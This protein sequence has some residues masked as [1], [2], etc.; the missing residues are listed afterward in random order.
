ML[1]RF[2]RLAAHA[3]LAE[4]GY[5]SAESIGAGACGPSLKAEV[6]AFARDSP[7]SAGWILGGGEGSGLGF[8]ACRR[9][10]SDG[11]EFLGVL[12]VG[13]PSPRAGLTPGQR[14]A[15]DDLAALAVA[16]LEQERR[17][18]LLL[19]V[20]GRAA[21]ADRI[22]RE[23]SESV[24]CEEALTRVLSALC[25][26]HGASVGRIWRLSMPD[27][28]MH[29]VSR[30]A[31][32]W[33]DQHPYYL[34]TPKE[35]VRA[36]NSQTAASIVANQPHT[37]IYSEVADP[38]HYA[39]LE[40]A[41]SAGLRSQVSFP[42]WVQEQRFGIA[43]AFMTERHDLQEIV[44][45]IAS[46]SNT[47][48]PAL[49]RKVTEERIRFMAHHDELTQLSNR[50][51][52]NERL[53]EAMQAVTVRD[54][55]ALLY[56][57]LDGF[58][59]VN[60]TRGHEVGDKLL[61]AAAARLR[62]SVPDGDTVAR[63]GGDEFAIIHPAAGQPYSA[64]QLARVLL[65]AFT[66][67]FD[68]D[69]PPLLIGASIG[70]AFHP[71]DGQTPDVLQRSADAALYAA[72]HGGRNTFRL[73][74]RALGEAKQDRLLIERDL[75]DA[76][77]HEEFTLVYQPIVA[78]GSLEVC[79]LEA[80]LRWTHPTRGPLSPARFV[81][82]AEETGLILPLG[83]WALNAACMQA[84]RWRN[85]VC[86]SVNFS[87]MQF[88]QAGLARQIETV[89]AETGLPAHRLDMEVT[90]GVLLDDS[91]LV[92]RTMHELRE[93]GVRM[94]LD[95]FGTAYASLGYLRRF[96][97]DRIKI[98]RSFIQGMC[99]DD[100]TL[101]IVQAILSLGARLKLQV[102]AEGVETERELSTLRSLDCALV[103]GFL[104]GKPML[105]ADAADLAAGA[106]S[107]AQL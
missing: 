3:A 38:E 13:D 48:R 96:P 31:D 9:L 62:A 54:G 58:K 8:L 75:K 82:I 64:T 30:F 5:I 53:L 40:A 78:A 4:A 86:L 65:A 102:V 34:L 85:G 1:N 47:I 107:L 35:P 7:G 52:F 12:C 49:F 25:H 23:V 36:G 45:D 91:G 88:R 24:S 97:F 46:L 50:A 19:E 83:D 70:I 69:G 22:L 27:G 26:Y 18:A 10:L 98:D 41:I 59:L 28:M 84:A 94:T 29:E 51:V 106:H 66:L 42:I 2:A 16:S 68:I 87:P 55:L 21:R 11:G 61:A 73:F 99:D 104:T 95:D 63:L 103:Q 71:A 33:L 43:L 76:I 44:G 79:G 81:P 80:L 56:L 93:M 74:E 6:T 72:K 90:E 57:D 15:L 14:A 101:A 100:A 32:D 20:T 17:H 92:L 105:Q 60:D 89:L 37:S 67:P 77:E 39:L